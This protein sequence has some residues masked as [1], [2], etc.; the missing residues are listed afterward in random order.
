MW[1]VDDISSDPNCNQYTETNLFSK[2]TSKLRQLVFNLKGINQR[3][4]M[5][6]Y[7][8]GFRVVYLGASCEN[9]KEVT[10]KN[11]NYNADYKI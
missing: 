1:K 6:I 9:L 8:K 4:F 3:K 11:Y 10:E 5:K 2:Q 7:N